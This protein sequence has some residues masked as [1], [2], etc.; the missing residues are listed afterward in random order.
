MIYAQR[1][2][3]TDQVL[4]E[5]SIASGLTRARRTA[6]AARA[7][8]GVAGLTLAVFWPL[9][10]TSPLLAGIGFAIVL[11]T[12]IVQLLV[13]RQEWLMVEESTRSTK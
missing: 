8:M 11:A 9:K 2:T 12:S 4:V 3:L 5:Q 10:G 6:A 1:P 7:T 13:P